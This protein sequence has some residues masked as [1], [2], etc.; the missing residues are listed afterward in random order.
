[1]PLKDL[2]KQCIPLHACTGFSFVPSRKDKSRFELAAVTNPGWI[3]TA[4]LV[5]HVMRMWKVFNAKSPLRISSFGLRGGQTILAQERCVEQITS[6][7]REV[8]PL[9]VLEIW[10]DC[11]TKR[12][13]KA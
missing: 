12:S 1:M 13:L 6:R 9:E 2:K 5:D 8:S 7:H 3:R 11:T 10:A 4:A